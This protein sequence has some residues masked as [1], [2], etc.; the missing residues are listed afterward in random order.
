ML[1]L[2]LIAL[3]EFLPTGGFGLA[4]RF[5][6]LNLRRIFFNWRARWRPH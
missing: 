6:G 1:W 2:Y 5:H 3:W 4:R